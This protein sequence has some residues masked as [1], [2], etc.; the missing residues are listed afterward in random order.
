MTRIHE[1]M[2]DTGFEVP[3][4]IEQA[5]VCR[6]SGMLPSPG[7]CEADPRGSAVHT[8]YFAKGTAPTEVCDHHVKYTVCAESGG[9]PTEYCPEESR[10]SRT[11]MVIPDGESG[12]TDDTHYRMPGTC[13]IHTQAAVVIPEETTA[14]SPEVPETTAPFIPSSP[15]EDIYIPK[16]PGYQ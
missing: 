6:K 9:I 14:E 4:S 16:G 10:V 11:F 1:G 2:A 15:L 3:S 5:A 12:G 7:V 13:P 8:E